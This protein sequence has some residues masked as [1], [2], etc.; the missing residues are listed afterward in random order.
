MKTTKTTTKKSDSKKTAPK[1]GSS[2]SAPAK[3]E[4]KPKKTSK[5]STAKELPK[6]EVVTE[7]KA[8]PVESPAMV[9]AAPPTSTTPTMSVEVPG[10]AISGAH[11]AK[12]LRYVLSAIPK[13]EGEVTFDL[14]D[15]GCPILSG[16]DQRRVHVAYLAEKAACELMGR[17]PRDEAADLADILEGVRGPRVRISGSGRVI[18]S[19]G[20]AQPDIHFAFAVRRLVATMRIPSQSGRSRA[21]VPLRLNTAHLAKAVK[22]PNTISSVFQASDGIA[23][24]TITDQE[25]G[26][27]LARAVIAEDGLDLYPEDDRQTE[28]PGSRTAPGA[29]TTGVEKAVDD[30]KRSIPAGTQMTIAVSGKAPVTLHGAGP[31]EEEVTIEGAEPLRGAALEGALGDLERWAADANASRC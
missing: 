27:L 21:A 20:T 16:H 25:S 8:A 23:F 1:K 2:K 18:V 26:T 15:M 4:S 14:D 17:V 3:V 29:Y 24:L 6:T 13:E 5:K 30:I 7:T 28:I 19:H 10:E 12:C 11:L 22:W 9:E 31:R